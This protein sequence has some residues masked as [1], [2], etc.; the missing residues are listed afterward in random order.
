M[1]CL[2]FFCQSNL[3]EDASILAPA[4]FFDLYPPLCGNHRVGESNSATCRIEHT[5]KG[6]LLAVRDVSFCAPG[7]TRTPTPSLTQHFECCMST[8]P[9]PGQMIENKR[10]SVV[11]FLKSNYSDIPH[12]QDVQTT[13]TLPLLYPFPANQPNI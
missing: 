4:G 2:L 3:A 9:S 12:C 7:E 13:K 6:T 1:N 8:I 5:P 11:T 10:I